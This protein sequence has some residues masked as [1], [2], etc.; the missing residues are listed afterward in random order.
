V[1]DVSIL[2]NVSFTLLPV[3]P[4]LLALRLWRAH[5]WC[6]SQRRPRTKDGIRVSD[7]P[8]TRL[9]LRLTTDSGVRGPRAAGMLAHRWS[10]Q[11]RT[12]LL[13]KEQ[14]SRLT[15]PLR[16]VTALKSSYATTSACVYACDTQ[17]RHTRSARPRSAVYM[18]CVRGWHSH[19]SVVRSSCSSC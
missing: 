19:P 1:D 2:H 9:R 10:V 3:L 17:S 16:V 6:V 5:M 14:P 4:R 11:T 15:I 13:W 8:D 7:Y 18:C 12:T